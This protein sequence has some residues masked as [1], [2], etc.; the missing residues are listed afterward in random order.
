VSD[1]AS[2]SAV[3]HVGV[4]GGATLGKTLVINTTL[5]ELNLYRAFELRGCSYV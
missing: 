2:V 4:A 5:T 3:N 1:C